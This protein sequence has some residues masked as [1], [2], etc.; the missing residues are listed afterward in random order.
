MCLVNAQGPLPGMDFAAPDVY[1]QVTPAGEVPIPLIST[2]MRATEVPK[3]TKVLVQCMPPHNVMDQ[4]PVT[5]SGP[6]RGAVSSQVCS[7]SKSMKCSTKLILQNAPATRAL[8]DPTGQ[9][10]SVPNSLGNTI[11]PSQ[12]RMVNPSP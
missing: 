12:I 11:V 5:I 4:A 2:G 1:M 9:N 8:M 3:C 7:A 6:G 10:G